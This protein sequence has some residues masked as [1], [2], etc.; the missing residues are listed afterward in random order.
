MK[1]NSEIIKKA[2]ELIKNG[3]PTWAEAVRQAIKVYQAFVKGLVTFF[4]VPKGDEETTVTTRRI[5]RLSDYGVVGS[6][7]KKTATIKVIDLDKFEAT[8]DVL[9]SIISFHAWQII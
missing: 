2:W 4:K 9:K 6:S 7:D 8:G 1:F 3:V 5:G